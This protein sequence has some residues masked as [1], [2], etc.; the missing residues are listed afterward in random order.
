MDRNGDRAGAAGAGAPALPGCGSGRAPAAAR[1]A[2]AR[3][4][5]MPP[6]GGSSSRWPG[7]VASHPLPRIASV[8]IYH[9]MPW[10]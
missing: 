1:P 8:Y 10:L 9:S 2:P 7:P 6:P 5:G 4:P 3:Q